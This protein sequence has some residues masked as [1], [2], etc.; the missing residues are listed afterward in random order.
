[1]LQYATYAYV[2]Q[3]DPKTDQVQPGVLQ[4][5]YDVQKLAALTLTTNLPPGI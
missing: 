5:H 2:G 3:L 4:V 1:M